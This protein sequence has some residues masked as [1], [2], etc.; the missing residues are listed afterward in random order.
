M[1]KSSNGEKYVH[2]KVN[3]IVLDFGGT[4]Y[5]PEPSSVTFKDSEEV[6]PDETDTKP[7]ESF[8]LDTESSLIGTFHPRL[9]DVPRICLL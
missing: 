2:L 6:P 8:S 4:L 3:E 5:R 7:S 9:L 1:H